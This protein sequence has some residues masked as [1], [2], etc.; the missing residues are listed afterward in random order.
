MA[1]IPGLPGLRAEII[2]NDI[3][4]KEYPPPADSHED[5]PSSVTS[6]IE[7][8]DDSKFAI[9][10]HID[11]HFEYIEGDL[12]FGIR[13]DGEKVRNYLAD[14]KNHKKGRILTV[15]Y[16]TAGSG[17]NYVKREFFF[18]LLTTGNKI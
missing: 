11:R 7:A 5:A 8:A 1:I 15:D 4:R 9:R 18:S 13:L 10:I 17:E 12:C 2:V 6:Y 16:A 3:A 14:E